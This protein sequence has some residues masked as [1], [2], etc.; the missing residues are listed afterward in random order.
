MNDS[1]SDDD[2]DDSVVVR[3]RAVAEKDGH[4]GSKFNTRGIAKF[5][6]KI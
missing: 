2:D 3:E 6:F 1:S 5:D 4:M